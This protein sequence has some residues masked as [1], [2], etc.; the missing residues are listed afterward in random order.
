[1]CTSIAPPITSWV[2]PDARAN[3]ECIADPVTVQ[4]NKADSVN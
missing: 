1:L 4:G 3:K 2:L